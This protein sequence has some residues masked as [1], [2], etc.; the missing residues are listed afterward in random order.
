MGLLT[1]Q[2]MK[3]L[4]RRVGFEVHDGRRTG[5]STERAFRILADCYRKPGVPVKVVDHENTPKANKQLL[6][7]IQEILARLR[8]RHFDFDLDEATVTLRKLEE[9][10]EG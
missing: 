10:K 1:P 3:D 5:R 4:E 9:R 8:F 2:L 6:F 7:M